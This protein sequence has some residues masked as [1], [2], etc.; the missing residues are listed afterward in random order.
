VRP[1]EGG[2]L[3]RVTTHPHEVF[4]VDERLRLELDPRQLVGIE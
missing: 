4:E 2:L 1:A 3:L